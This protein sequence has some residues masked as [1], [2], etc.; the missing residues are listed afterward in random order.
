MLLAKYVEHRAAEIVVERRSGHDGER[1]D[2]PQRALRILELGCGTGLAGLAAASA[3]GEQLREEGVIITPPELDIRPAA[4]RN[5][6]VAGGESLVE[7]V[8][9]DLPYALEN[10]RANVARNAE[11]L[12]AAGVGL[13][14]RELDWL[15]PVPQELLGERRNESRDVSVA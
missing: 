12:D 11:P 5:R 13:V 8:L 14:V 3:L 7:A 4:R 1:G 15:R 2:S 10:T 9:T 6:G